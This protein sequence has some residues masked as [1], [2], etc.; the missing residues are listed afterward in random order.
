L[1]GSTLKVETEDSPQ[2]TGIS[3]G[4]LGYFGMSN[5]RMTKRDIES[6]QNCEDHRA[7][8]YLT[9]LEKPMQK[10]VS[11]M[12]LPNGISTCSHTHTQQ[13]RKSLVDRVFWFWFGGSALQETNMSR[14]GNR[15]IIDSK[16][17][18]FGGYVSAQE[19]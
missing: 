15:K 4:K 12:H 1:Y 5:F 14:L 18:K 11:S 10:P 16:V 17:P 13:I 19:G 9:K 2:T 3:P 6:K 7:L 8:S